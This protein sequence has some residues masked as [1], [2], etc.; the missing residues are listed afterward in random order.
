MNTALFWTS[1]FFSSPLF[2]SNK[3]NPTWSNFVRDFKQK[4]GGTSQDRLQFLSPRLGS[5]VYTQ[6]SHT[7]CDA[8]HW[9]G[10]YAPFSP[11]SFFF[12]L[13]IKAWIHCTEDNQWITKKKTK[14]N[15]TKQ[16]KSSSCSSLFC[17]AAMV[18]GHALV[19]LGSLWRI[20]AGCRLMWGERWLV[21]IIHHI[22]FI[23]LDQR[24]SLRSFTSSCRH[25]AAKYI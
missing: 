22:E 13:R 21:P 24:Q 10:V 12:F 6:F 18:E 4:P 3:N 11:L 14:Q 19:L 20:A 2:S 7:G 25:A 15:K 23:S 8:A 9:T 5:E 16:K 1:F 17:L